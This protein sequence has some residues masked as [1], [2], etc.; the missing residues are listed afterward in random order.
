MLPVSEEAVSPKG[1]RLSRGAALLALLGGGAAFTALADLSPA[2]AA[3]SRAQD[4]KILNYLLVLEQLQEAFYAAARR[5]GALSGEPARYADL[6]N[7]NEHAH[8]QLLTKLLGA[9]AK[10]APR[11]R[12]GSAVTTRRA[13]VRTAVELEETAVGAYIATGAN[14]TDRVMA[15]VGSICAVEGR[16]AAWIRSIADELPAPAA[17]DPAETQQRVLALVRR[18]TR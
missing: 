4:Q 8:V 6:V 10:P 5:G 13:F 2:E 11:F 18:F 7:R 15:H 16:H 1:R 14:L 9:A 3:P 17:A 12:F